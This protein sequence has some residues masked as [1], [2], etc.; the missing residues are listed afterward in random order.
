MSILILQLIIQN[1][2]YRN[3]LNLTYRRLV[4]SFVKWLCF[5][6]Y[7][8]DKNIFQLYKYTCTTFK[9]LQLRHPNAL[10][11]IYK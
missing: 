5:N 10:N 7:N 6:L 3:V 4:L 9:H 1:Y 2:D 8:N 11:L